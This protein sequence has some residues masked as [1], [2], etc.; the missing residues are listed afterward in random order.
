[1][2]SGQAVTVT[3]SLENT[4]AADS[5]GSALTLTLPA[6]MSAPIALS[7]GM[8]Y[9]PISHTVAWAGDLPVAAAQVLTFT[10][11]AESAPITC[12]A[13]SVSG[14]V[15][16]VLAASTA[17]SATVN[18]AVPDVDCSGAVNVIDIQLVAGRWGAILGQPEYLYEYDLNG[19]DAIDVIDITIAANHWN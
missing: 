1:M 8:T 18:L 11:G 3:A 12:T 15:V 19:N 2:G 5:P 17:L 7:P 13:L 14:D 10:A 9:S 6:A 4:G 16:D